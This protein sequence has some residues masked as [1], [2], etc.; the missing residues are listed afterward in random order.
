MREA[1]NLLWEDWVDESDAD[2]RTDFHGLQMIIARMVEEAGECFVRR[3]KPTA[4]GRPGGTSAV[5]GAPA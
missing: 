5:A 4:G 3:R 1:L 2:D